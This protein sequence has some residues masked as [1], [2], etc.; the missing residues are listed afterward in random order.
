MLFRSDSLTQ[1]EAG[2]SPTKPALDPERAV[3]TRKL[4]MTPP[5]AR[6]D[7][8]QPS[9]QASSSN[10]GPLLPSEVMQ[11][12]TE[13]RKRTRQEIEALEEAARKKVST[14]RALVSSPAPEQMVARAGPSKLRK[15]RDVASSTDDESGKEKDKKKKSGGVFGGLF[16]RKDKEKDKSKLDTGSTISIASDTNL[17]RE[18][19]DSNQSKI[20]RAHV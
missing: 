7:E 9:V 20:G 13:E 2:S 18:S 19:G 10:V 8:A 6:T 17:S 1:E 12:Q 5:V 15:E 3:E 14:G 16:R 11:K 4:S